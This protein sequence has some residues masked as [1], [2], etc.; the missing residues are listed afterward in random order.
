[1][2]PSLV[3]LAL[4]PLCLAAKRD[5]YGPPLATEC[6]TT[7]SVSLVIVIRATAEVQRM[8]AAHSTDHAEVRA[9]TT[10]GP[11]G[12][13]VLVL[14]PL[15]GQDDAETMRVWGHELAHSVCGSFHGI[16]AAF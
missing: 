11:D 2:K 10:T 15:R 12:R 16:G 5:V 13:T 4:L 6:N 7:A 9:F 14:P 8:Y 3:I 1:M